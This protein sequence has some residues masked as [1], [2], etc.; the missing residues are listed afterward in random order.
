MPITPIPL[1]LARPGIAMHSH[2]WPPPFIPTSSSSLS[3]LNQWRHWGFSSLHPSHSSASSF[4]SLSL[5]GQRLR[6]HLHLQR[7]AASQLRRRQHLQQRRL[8]K[9]PHHEL[10][11]SETEFC[12]EKCEQSLASA[13]PPPRLSSL[14]PGAVVPAP[15]FYAA[16][17]RGFAWKSYLDG[18]R[19]LGLWRS[20][21]WWRAWFLP[22][23][24]LGLGL[25]LEPRPKPML[26]K[27]PCVLPIDVI[28]PGL[29][30]EPRPIY[31]DEGL[32]PIFLVKV[33][34]AHFKLAHRVA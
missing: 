26:K 11:H 34:H 25:N 21:C 33:A 9:L 16:F 12:P 14:R 23:T 10:L 13:Q 19:G 15:L 24:T 17:G 30:L 29:K 18:K 27:E 32:M 4:S 8:L 28:G 5:R 3:R 22:M 31:T 20:L 2:A 1:T 7:S 6:L